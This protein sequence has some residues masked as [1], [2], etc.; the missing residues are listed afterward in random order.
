MPS[1]SSTIDFQVTAENARDFQPKTE[2]K[3]WRLEEMC[4]RKKV[5]ENSARLTMKHRR[6]RVWEK[7][8]RC[9]FTLPNV[10]V[11]YVQN[12]PAYLKT[13]NDC[14]IQR[15]IDISLYLLLLEIAVFLRSSM[16]RSSFKWSHSH[17]LTRQHTPSFT[18]DASEP[19]AR[20]MPQHRAA[21]SCLLQLQFM[22]MCSRTSP[23]NRPLNWTNPQVI[24]KKRTPPFY[25]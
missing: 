8:D 22:G 10:S 20:C 24:L 17:R 5:Y 11:K 21:L 23:Q 18:P 3:K 1:G 12:L 2:T 13:A 7:T 19:G 25:P 15:Q 9:H 14:I 16:L 6:P 4:P